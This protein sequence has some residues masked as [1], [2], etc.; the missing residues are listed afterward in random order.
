MAQTKT[1]QERTRSITVRRL[2]TICCSLVVISISAQPIIDYVRCGCSYRDVTIGLW[3][4]ALKPQVWHFGTR[5]LGFLEPEVNTFGQEDGAGA[6]IYITLHFCIVILFFFSKK[7]CPFFKI[8]IYL[9]W[10]SVPKEIFLQSVKYICSPRHLCST[11][12][13]NLD[14]YFDTYLHLCGT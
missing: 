3:T 8:F 5:H 7:T 2:T 10:Y 13:F 4:P 9:L 1:C 11:T 6:D 12:I 14:L